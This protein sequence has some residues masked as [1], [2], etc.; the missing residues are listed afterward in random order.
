MI[1]SLGGYEFDDDS[2]D[3]LYGGPGNDTIYGG[4]GTDALYGGLG[5]DNLYGEVVPGDTAETPD[6]LDGGFG[7]DTVW[8]SDG[9]TLVGGPGTD[10]FGVSFSDADQVVPT[11]IEDF[12]EGEGVAIVSYDPDFLPGGSKPEDLADDYLSLTQ[13]SEGVSV[14]LLTETG[15]QEVMMVLNTT[16]AELGTALHLFD[17]SQ[18][19]A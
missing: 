5:N 3:T 9:D 6:L 10:A 14:S 18:P 12:E 7:D 19:P 13:T 8:G 11:V 2:H 15:S 1:T 4:T 17:Q 16:V